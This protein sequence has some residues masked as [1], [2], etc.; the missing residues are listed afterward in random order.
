V[1]C[2]LSD[3]RCAIVGGLAAATM[4]VVGCTADGAESTSTTQ[5]D[6]IDEFVGA[7]ERHLT[8]TWVIEGTTSRSRV[9][10]E[11][12]ALTGEF[13]EVQRPPDRLRLEMD[14]L[15]GEVDGR[16]VQCAGDPLGCTDLGEAIPVDAETAAAVYR[17]YV[18]GPDAPYEL[19]SEL[20]AE[21]DA[22]SCFLLT[23]RPAPLPPEL[24]DEITFCFHDATGSMTDS[25]RVSG[26]VVVEQITDRASGIVTDA[27]FVLPAA[28]G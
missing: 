9:G 10:G 12:A 13:R 2:F 14:V 3:L 24:G 6:L 21:G 15:A 8:S 28:I 20:G 22:L 1:G 23:A 18:D 4:L 27:D 5:A 26:D 7:W 25:R 11:G 17:T 19:T 16:R